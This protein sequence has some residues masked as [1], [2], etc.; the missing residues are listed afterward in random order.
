MEIILMSQKSILTTRL[1]SMTVKAKARRILV[2]FFILALTMVFA[3][4]TQAAPPG[5]GW[6]LLYAD[7]FGG[8][9]VDTQKWITQYPWGPTHDAG[10]DAYMLAQNLSVANGV[11][12]ETAKRETAPDG[13]AFTSGVIS[14]GYSLLNYTN[15]YAEARIKLPSRLGAFPAFWGLYNG[16]PPEVD[17][18][19]YPIFTSGMNYNKYNIAYHYTNTSGAAASYGPGLLDAGA[20]SLA[21][22]WHTYGMD[23]TSTYMDFYFDGV[24]KSH[25]T[26][27]TAIAQMK[28]MYLILNFAVG[29]WAGVPDTTQWP[30]GA[31]DTTQVDWVRVWKN[32]SGYTSATSWNLAGNGSW[33]TAS[34]WTSGSPQLNTQIA[35]FGSVAAT[36]VA[37]DWSNSKTVGGLVFNSS[38][39]YTLGGGTSNDSVMLTSSTPLTS[40]QP[41]TSVVLIDASSATGSSPNVIN[42]RLELYNNVTIR[43]PNKPMTLNGPITGLGA[44]RIE[45]GQITLNKSATYSGTTTI[46]GGTLRLGASPVTVAHRWSFNNSLAD[47]VGTSN[48]T[49][50]D[51]GANN[52]TLGATQATLTGGTSTTSDYIRLGSNLLPNTNTSVAIE[53][54]ATP[55]SVQN[56]GRIFDF[57][58]SE[59]ENLFMAWTQGTNFNTDK[60]GWRDAVN[61]TDTNISSVNS[62][63]PYNLNTEYHIVMQLTPIGTSTEVKWYVAPTTSANLGPA[64]GS[65]ITTATLANFINSQDSLG[66][67][68]YAADST[69]NASYDEVRLWSGPINSTMLEL[70][71]DA[72]PDAN[73]STLNLGP[74][75]GELPTNT[76]LNIT[77][78]GATLDLNGV[79][80]TV[81]SLAGV[82]GSSVL[83]GTGTL[84]VGG[85]GTST[86]FSGT[87]SGAGGITKT[88]AGTF[89][90][91]GANTY[92]GTTL[93]TGGTL[94]LG[95]AGSIA[96]NVID[97][98]SGTFD[99]T[100]L[101]NYSLNS[102]QTI[103]GNGTVRGSMTVFGTVQPG[104]SPGIL[105][106]GDITFGNGSLLNIEIAGA[107][108]GTLYDMI[109]SSGTINLQ[110]GS[111][112]KL[113]LING[114]TPNYG[115]YFDIL[116]F[117]SISGT[118]TTIDL[119]TLPDGEYWNLDNL[120]Q[121][122]SLSVVPEP[123][124]LVMIFMALATIG[125]WIYKRR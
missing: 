61:G 18:M 80:Q 121:N 115:D 33:D 20:G 1:S 76:T 15:G 26:D 113:S 71:H 17:I 87:I 35:T 32:T 54:W 94:K 4:S 119:P 93:I 24:R 77:A 60:V 51:V 114:Y 74:A 65:F 55:K 40:D 3:Q 16:W 104:E 38:V 98:R 123:A 14:T 37:V 53:L 46:A 124:T 111:K 82:A 125:C 31:T 95:N 43:S 100:S 92:T 30:V 47:S 109:N 103:K 85:N 69:A 64:K 108:P 11:L 50:V 90:M 23:W 112:L 36:N 34:N 59:S 99:V 79:N 84:T 89:T 49:I 88:G 72:G 73:L 117:S 75:G 42:T 44:L 81:G 7:E 19:E 2:C 118:F 107:T 68:I 39:N 45:S 83:L 48:A 106:T 52:V 91:S 96:G 97:I 120:Y 22:T 78:S 102:D 58:S 6:G 66:R 105:S 9:S 25:I 28:S 62:T 101:P 110:D 63:E 41:N 56:W 27:A 13:K 57:G 67:S 21:N 70:L 116:I 8:S 10:N 12:T 122:G 86:A 5:S 29:N